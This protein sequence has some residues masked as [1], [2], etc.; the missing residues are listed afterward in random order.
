ME[1][2]IEAAG[3]GIFQIKLIALTGFAYEPNLFNKILLNSCGNIKIASAMEM[4]ILSVLA[5]ALSC[6]WAYKTTK[7]RSCQL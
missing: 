5:P 6:D 7:R 2:A 1:E 3:F 4:M